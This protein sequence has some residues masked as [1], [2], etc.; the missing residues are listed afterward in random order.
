M[1]IFD[2]NLLDEKKKELQ[3][4]LEI[5]NKHYG[6]IPVCPFSPIVQWDGMDSGDRV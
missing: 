5:V 6:T 2:E 1:N 4:V 3:Y